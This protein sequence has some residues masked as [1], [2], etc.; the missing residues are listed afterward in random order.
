MKSLQVSVMVALLWQSQAKRHPTH[1][2]TE[3]KVGL[4]GTLKD[5][6]ITLL[7]LMALE[8]ITFTPVTEW[9]GSMGLGVAYRV[10]RPTPYAV[11]EENIS[12]LWWY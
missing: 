8:D 1:S 5:G 3:D 2:N 11:G 6:N 12:F 7:P 9:K 10:Y 4:N